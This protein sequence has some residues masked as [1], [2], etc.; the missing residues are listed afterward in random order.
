MLQDADQ[1]DKQKLLL[2]QANI[3]SYCDQGIMD[4][5]TY[6][7]TATLWG[8]YYLLL[9]TILQVKTLRFVKTT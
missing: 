6:I 3:C 8:K 9:D 5:I 1:T 2:L 7:F 4:Y